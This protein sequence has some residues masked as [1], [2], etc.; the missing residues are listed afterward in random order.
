[1]DSSGVVSVEVYKVFTL[2]ASLPEEQR[3]PKDF[4]IE[5]SR[6]IMIQFLYRKKDCISNEKFLLFIHQESISL[7]QVHLKKN[8]SCEMEL[9][10]CLNTESVV[11]EFSW[12][13]WDP[14]N[15]S[16]YYIHYRKTQLSVE[17]E[18][19]EEGREEE[20]S[21][22]LSCLQFHDDM[23]H[24]TVL[25]IPLN[26]PQLSKTSVPCGGYEDDP[27]PLRVHDCSLD[28]QVVCDTKG[29]VCICHHY[30]YQ[31]V[32]PPMTEVRNLEESST[33]VHFAY[34]VTLLH[35]GCV[36]HC[37]VPGILWSQARTMKPTF[38]LY[39][40]QHMAVYAPGL[41]THLLDIGLSHEPCCHILMSCTLPGI[42]FYTSHLVPL[43]QYGNTVTVDLP[44][45]DLIPLTVTTRHLIET[46]KNDHSLENQL[47]ILHYFLVHQGDLETISEVIQ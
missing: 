23:P 33:T 7:N 35:H 27:I 47:A 42:P 14:I 4:G 30:L 13:Q 45:L 18:E 22:T 16:L 34:S 6:Q 15:Q 5:R 1:M 3:E 10:G 2:D 12:A 31:P 28:L 36:I 25:N 19:P 9:C 20:L 24:E 26:L 39:G 41:F 37:V 29:V 44:S 17:G 32:K 38:A 40:D 8:G 46:F 43:L 21:P 11:R